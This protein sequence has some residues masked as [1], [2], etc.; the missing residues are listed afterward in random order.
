MSEDSFTTV[1]PK[2]PT[3]CQ[4]FPGR[5]ERVSDRDELQWSKDPKVKHQKM[6]M[7]SMGKME[8]QRRRNT[9]LPGNR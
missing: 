3:L 6:T 8:S 5:E 4:K 9:H 1:P 7:L 2:S